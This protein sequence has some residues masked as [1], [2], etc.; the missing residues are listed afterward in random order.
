M[1]NQWDKRFKAEDYMYGKK[2]N[3]FIKQIVSKLKKGKVL[4]IAEGE[5]R[6][7]VFLAE[8]GFDVTTWDFSKVGLEK[9][10][11]LAKERG[12]EVRAELVDL[13]TAHWEEEKWDVIINV[14]GHFDAETKAR[15]LSGIASALKPGGMFVTEVYSPDQ[16]EYKTGGPQKLEMLYAPQE[17]LEKF[18]SWKFHH[19]YFG[20]VERYEGQLHTGRCHVIQALIEKTS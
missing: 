8:Q 10:A 4:A 18:S 1:E 14:F 19:F 7:A 15:T 12:V 16:L 6:N 11:K 3:E 5:G 17:I 20:E 13:S 2:P 9:T